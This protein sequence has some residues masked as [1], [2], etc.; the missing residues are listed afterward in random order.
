MNTSK[1]EITDCAR[2]F[3]RTSTLTPGDVVADIIEN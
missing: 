1:T 2:A 3:S